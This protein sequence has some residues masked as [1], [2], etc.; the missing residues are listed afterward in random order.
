MRQIIDWTAGVA[1]GL[2]VASFYVLAALFDMFWFLDWTRSAM[3]P[4]WG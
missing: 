3:P 1:M 2:F 4:L